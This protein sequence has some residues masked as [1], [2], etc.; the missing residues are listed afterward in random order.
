MDSTTKPG[1]HKGVTWT[2]EAWVVDGRRIMR[3]PSYSELGYWCSVSGLLG[4]GS[5]AIHENPWGVIDLALSLGAAGLRVEPPLPSDLGERLPRLQLW[6][7]VEN[8]PAL[9]AGVRLLD[10]G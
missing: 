6:L 9:L 3:A 5:L 10:P 2:P 1:P 4:L 8:A 7:P